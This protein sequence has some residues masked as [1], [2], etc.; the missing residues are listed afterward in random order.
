M[1]KV[2]LMGICGM[3]MGSLAAMLNA[4]GCE[5]RGS[6]Q[7]VYPPMSD[8]L[9]ELGIVY[10]EGFQGANLDWGPDLVVVGNVITRRNPE[11]LALQER[12]LP[13]TSLPK[14]IAERFIGDRHAVVVTGTHGKTTTSGLLAWVLKQS[15]RD[16]AFLVGGVLKNF[17]ASYGLGKGKHFVIEGD[18]YDTAYFDKVPKFVHYRPT[19]GLI[20]SIEFD[21]ADIYEDLSRI[22]QE[23]GKFVD[24]IPEDGLLT[25]CIDDPNVCDVIQGTDVPVQT[26][27]FSPA[28]EWTLDDIHVGTPYT[29]F[30]IRHKGNIFGTFETPMIGRHNL[31]NMLGASALLHGLGLS[32]EEIST[33]FRS[34][35][36]VTRRQELR[37]IVNDIVVLDDFA[38]HPT[39]VRLTIEA[40]RSHYFAETGRIGRL[41][42]VF[43]PRSATSRRDIFQQD[44][45][46]A[47]LA[48]DAVV[49]AAVHLPEKAPEGHRFSPTKLI[50]QLQEHKVN[51]R[52]IA[53]VDSIVEDLA[54]KTRP[55]DVV[56]IMSNGGFGD[57][58]HKLLHALQS[59]VL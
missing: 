49:I 42:S 8:Q 57:I 38:H 9:A 2:H 58:H 54:E 45:V 51:A 34:F 37:G 50:R 15:G 59:Q 56:L 18:E 13:Y 53:D 27:G 44:Y 20:T 52:H 39:A 5:L 36:G 24:L 33:G 46:K 26:Y 7:H 48:S 19:S 6:D 17:N 12:G 41:W 10:T 14:L 21:H 16:P 3:A 55:G 29:R 32:P 23:F 22:K 47:F 11:A 1:Q 28:A 35:Q 4:E 43:E 40:V 30:C 25:A 31:L